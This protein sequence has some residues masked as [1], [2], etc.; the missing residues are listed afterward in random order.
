MNY[1]K[2]LGRICGAVGVTMSA[3]QIP[4]YPILVTPFREIYIAVQ[5]G[6]IALGVYATSTGIG[7]GVEGAK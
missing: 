6:I 5:T 3:M 4:L 7:N 2:T 1:W